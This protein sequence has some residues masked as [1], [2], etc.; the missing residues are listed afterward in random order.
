M[1]PVISYRLPHN[2]RSELKEPLGRLYPKKTIIDEIHRE[3]LRPAERI[4]TVG[5]VITRNILDSGITINIA[6]IDGKTERTTKTPP[7]T[8][9][10]Y[11]V[12]SVKNPPATITEELINALKNA[13]LKSDLTMIMVDG[14]EDLAALPAVMLSPATSIVMYGQPGVGSVLI[15]VDDAIRKRV[16]GLLERMRV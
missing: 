11:H 8:I 2:L 9:Q 6:V 3:L 15:R 12:V 1:R 13:L 14:E 7:L 5:D 10:G 16:E 4:I